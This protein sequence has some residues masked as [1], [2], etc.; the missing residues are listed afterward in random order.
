MDSIIS[1]LQEMVIV[2]VELHLKLLVG[3]YESI[4]VLHR[5][6]HM[7]V[8]VCSTMDDEH[9]ARYVLYMI[10]KGSVLISPVI[11]LRPTHITLRI[12]AIIQFP[13][14]NRGDSHSGFERMSL[15]THGHERL[16]SA[17]TPAENSHA[18]RIYIVP[19]ADIISRSDE[20]FRLF[21][22]QVHVCLITPCT[23][24]AITT[25]TIHNEHGI[26]LRHKRV[27]KALAPTIEY[28]LTART[29]I[30]HYYQRRGA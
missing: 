26:A 11:H 23:A 21:G 2:R 22:T 29:T 20:V 24:T 19:P 15:G 7:H 28:P 6:L 10:E 3:P 17:I 5:L 27:L 12:G 18:V 8:I 30:V 16:V 14:R 9:I 1:F 4:D 25:P 13:V